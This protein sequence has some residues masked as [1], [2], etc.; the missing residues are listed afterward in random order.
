MRS[1]PKTRI[2]VVAALIL[3]IISVGIK[4]HSKLNN[5]IPRGLEASEVTNN[6]AASNM[7]AEL[8]AERIFPFSPAEAINSVQTQL[9][10]EA[11]ASTALKE[12]GSYSPK[13]SNPNGPIPTNKPALVELNLV[14]IPPGE[15]LLGSPEGEVGRRINEGPQTRVRISR[16]FWLASYETTVTQYWKVTGSSP[17][18]GTKGV[19]DNP[20]KPCTHVSWAQATN[21]CYL[22]TRYERD[23]NRLPDGYVYRLP[24]EAEWEYA[25]R[26]GTATRYSFGDDSDYELLSTYAWFRTNVILSL[27]E[28]HPVGIKAPNPWGLYDMH[29]NALEWCWDFILKY[30][31]GIVTDFV[32]TASDSRG[33]HLLRGGGAESSASDCR[34]AFRWSGAS[35]EGLWNSGFRVALAP[36]LSSD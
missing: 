12:T 32:G 6:D 34:S 28:A 1:T 22:L 23:A 15:F 26:A 7:T 29:G 5:E 4:L 27:L 19:N 24:T 33:W 30:P 13:T 3:L 11:T 18:R 14:S 2:V 31:G 16:G 35:D 8:A 36:E 17:V 10:G 9:L 25:C 20:D 21:F